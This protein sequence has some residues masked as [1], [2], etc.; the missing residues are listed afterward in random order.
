MKCPRCGTNSRKGDAFCSRCGL[1]I[2]APQVPFHT[3]LQNNATPPPAHMGQIILVALTFFVGACLALGITA[4]KNHWF[5]HSTS[6]SLAYK[7]EARRQPITQSNQK[8][9]VAKLGA[10]TQTQPP[11]LASNQTLQ[12]PP[13]QS[14]TQIKPA[15]LGNQTQYAPTPVAASLSLAPPLA[16]TFS[17]SQVPK[18]G[19][20]N[21]QTPAIPQFDL[22][23]LEHLQRCELAKR[24]LTKATNQR[25]EQFLQQFQGL[26]GNPN[27]SAFRQHTHAAEGD[28]NVAGSRNI[29]LLIHNIALQ[30]T[31][32]QQRFD[33]QVPPQ[34][35]QAIATDYDAGLAGLVK[36]ALR[37]DDILNGVNA[38]DRDRNPVIQASVQKL[39]RI[40]ATHSLSVDQNF[41]NADSAVQN[42]CDSYH[43]KKW[44][45]IDASGGTLDASGKSSGTLKSLL[46]ILGN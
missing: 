40:N 31:Q 9:T 12:S 24:S 4:Y 15:P 2:F 29:N 1:P 30:W 5:A 6:Q 33:S 43:I 41:R 10:Q 36:T 25:L 7:Q 17:Q 23:W 3:E 42:V 35:C 32:L 46:G 13:L 26:L 19:V 27:S 18:L 11:P 28:Q 22:D 37:I 14:Q 44:F 39:E 45:S 38:V 8:L 20:T 21:M 16:T 34:D